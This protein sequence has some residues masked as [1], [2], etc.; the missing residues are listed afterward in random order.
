MPWSLLAAGK[1]RDP[2]VWRWHAHPEV[3]LLVG[4]LI[5]LYVYAARVIGPKVVTPGQPA[6]SRRQWGFFAGAILVLELSADWP[7]HDIGEEYLYS[8]H[9][10]Q[11]LLLTLV[12]PPLF[13][14]A[15]PRWLA[16]LIL[17]SG[18]VRRSVRWL[19]LPV[20]AGVTYN[21]VFVFMHWPPTVTAAVDSA[22]VHFGLHLLVVLAALAMW[23]P[24]CG[25]IEEWR[26]SLPAQMVYL[27]MMSVIPTVPGAWLTFASKPVYTVYDTPFRAY[28]ISALSDQQMAGL[29]M[30]LGGGIYLWTIITG[31]FFVWAGRHEAAQKAGRS[32]DER[33]VLTWQAVEHEFAQSKAPEEPTKHG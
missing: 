16:D 8:V 18:R 26:I 15:T 21:A 1:Y 13:L 29:I 30:K 3:W 5:V 10:V 32:V 4:S 20:T 25:P 6:V 11:H 12:V 2:D 9:M 22:P 17:G 14:L 24:I 27:F 33:D 28:G 23:T 31:L 19:V 7:M